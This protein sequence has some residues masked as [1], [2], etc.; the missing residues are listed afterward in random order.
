MVKPLKHKDKRTYLW[1]ILIALD[2]LFNTLLA[3][4]ADE[5]LSARAYRMRA[6][7][8]RWAIVRKVIDTI[9]FFEKDH[10]YNA[11]ISELI[12]N[13]KPDGYENYKQY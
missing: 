5:T 9:F 7:K 11:F 6:R 13:H 8:K 1:Q 4:Y 3:G 12:Q 10:C 2:Q